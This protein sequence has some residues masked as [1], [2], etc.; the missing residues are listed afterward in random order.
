[1]FKTEITYTDFL[2]NEV[3]ETLRFNLTETE[4]MDLI[5][6][7]PT[8]NT[9]FLSYI[10]QEQDYAKMMDVIRKLIVVSYGEVSDDGRHFRKSDAMALDFVQSAAYEAFR[11]KLLSSEDGSEFANF[12][13]GVFPQRMAESMKAAMKNRVG[14]DNVAQITG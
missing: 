9:G 5:R 12:L 3:T 1:M 4:L 6:E 8:F 13:L 2:G 14:Q 7:D 10:S 11:D